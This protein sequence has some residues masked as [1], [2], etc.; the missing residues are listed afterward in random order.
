MKTI[1]KFGIKFNGSDG[2][3]TAIIPEYKFYEWKTK[4]GYKQ[5]G[6][7]IYPKGFKSSEEVYFKQ[8]NDHLTGNP[9]KLTYYVPSEL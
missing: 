4:R 8:I 5:L 1:N 9:F 6:S 7:T 2:L 3:Y